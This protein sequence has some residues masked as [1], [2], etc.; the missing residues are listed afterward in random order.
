MLQLRNASPRAPSVPPF[1]VSTCSLLSLSAWPFAVTMFWPRA[2]NPFDPFQ[3]FTLLIGAT[4]AGFMSLLQPVHDS[5]WQPAWSCLLPALP[6]LAQATGITATQ[7]GA[8]PISIGLAFWAAMFTATILPSRLNRNG[9]MLLL[10]TWLGVGLVQT[11]IIAL[12]ALGMDPL[13]LIT[14]H[15]FALWRV[16]GTMGNPNLAAALLVPLVL[17]AT[18]AS[19]VTHRLTRLLLVAGLTAGVV[20]TGSRFAVILLFGLMLWR[21]ANAAMTSRKNLSSLLILSSGATILTFLVAFLMGKGM[22]SPMG[23]L[24]FWRTTVY[25]C[26]NGP[27]NGKGWM[28][29]ATVYPTG[30][31]KEVTSGIP[32][33]LP[34]HAHND[35]LEFGVEFGPA[36][37]LLPVLIIFFLLGKTRASACRPIIAALWSLVLL[38][39]WDSPLHEAPT[40]LLFWMLVGCAALQKRNRKPATAFTQTSATVVLLILCLAGLPP[41]YSRLKGHILAARAGSTPPPQ[42]TRLWRQAFSH[43][44]ME[45]YFALR[46]AVNHAR[47]GRLHDSF[48]WSGR[49]AAVRPD[50]NAWKVLAWSLGSMG[51]FEESLGFLAELRVFFPGV[52][53][54]KR[55]EQDI[56]QADTGSGNI[57]GNEKD[58]PEIPVR[59]G[60]R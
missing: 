28:S 33:A 29:F 43:A 56:R 2:W 23:R 15:H 44:P 41:V 39:S 11:M 8:W 49:A 42:N 37:W 7:Q 26:L 30:L 25:L 22:A 54:F 6:L 20:L 38:G 40:S 13:L 59:I 58:C 14:Q 10:R 27:W 36:G 21:F 9:R 1:G 3:Y 18:D 46:L 19:L 16:Y 4:V 47:S 50:F 53:S 48:A 35:W 5:S 34:L 45:G 12:Q 31:E 24:Q 57:T 60:G 32:E 55:L 17:L 51:C 52:Q